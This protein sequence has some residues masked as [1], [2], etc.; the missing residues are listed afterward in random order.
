M[1]HLYVSRLRELL[2][3]KVFSGAVIAKE[4]L[5]LAVE[6]LFSANMMIRTLRIYGTDYMLGHSFVAFTY[7]AWRNSSG[8]QILQRRVKQRSG[9]SWSWCWAGAPWC[10]RD[11]RYHYEKQPIIMSGPSS[12]TLPGMNTAKP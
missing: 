7:S 4:H 9:K 12:C 3:N 11:Y 2:R 1:G 10:L 8:R 5:D 6:Y